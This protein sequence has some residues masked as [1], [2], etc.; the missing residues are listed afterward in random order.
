MLYTPKWIFI[1]DIATLSM[2]EACKWMYTFIHPLI[3]LNKYTEGL[4]L[5]WKQRHKR[6][7]VQLSSVL[8]NAFSLSIIG[9]VS[10]SAC[11]K[12]P[13][14]FSGTHLWLHYMFS[15]ILRAPFPCWGGALGASWSL[16]PVNSGGACGHMAYSKEHD[17]TALPSDSQQNSGSPSPQLQGTDFR[18]QPQ[19]LRKK[20]QVAGETAEY[21]MS[22]M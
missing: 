1:H 18:Q 7:T 5:Y 8:A 3:I 4:G 9:K 11:I 10:F 12:L 19:G 17:V 15:P 20:A 2:F 6:K 21:L 14:L 22:L 13:Q 16:F